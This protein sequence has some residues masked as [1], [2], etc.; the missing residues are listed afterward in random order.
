MFHHGAKAVKAFLG[1]QS[2]NG[3]G[4][5]RLPLLFS[6]GNERIEALWVVFL[7]RVN[8]K[9]VLLAHPRFARPPCIEEVLL[10]GSCVCH[11]HW[12]LIP[13]R[14]N[15]FQS[16][17][18]ANLID[19]TLILCLLIQEEQSDRPSAPQGFFA[20]EIGEN[21]AIFSSRR[22]D[23]NPL[24]TVEEQRYALLRGLQ[25]ILWKI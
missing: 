17:L 25:D 20:A 24:K 13:E 1:A 8:G 7:N 9:L 21:R 16:H 11:V 18:V 22:R 3:A 5:P 23:L 4:L 15:S 10:K 2:N 6:P 19:R 14:H 12:D